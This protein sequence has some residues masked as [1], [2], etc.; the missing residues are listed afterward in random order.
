MLRG[1]QST[2]AT[3]AGSWYGRQHTARRRRLHE[4][5]FVTSACFYHRRIILLLGFIAPLRPAG[6]ADSLDFDSLREG[7]ADTSP[8]NRLTWVADVERSRHARTGGAGAGVGTVA[9]R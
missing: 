4:R 5:R 7:P 2:H 6:W 8:T 9:S 1:S 3:A